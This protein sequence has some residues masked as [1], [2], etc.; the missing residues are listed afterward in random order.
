MS[1]SSNALAD[2]LAG[3]SA[4]VM[5]DALYA[6]RYLSSRGQESPAEVLAVIKTHL[7]LS[8]QRALMPPNLLDRLALTLAASG[9]LNEAG[10]RLAAQ[11]VE[12]K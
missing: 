8:R 6:G 11:E 4:E 7:R 5:Y 10:E 9:Y 3:K 2:L 1:R 12:D